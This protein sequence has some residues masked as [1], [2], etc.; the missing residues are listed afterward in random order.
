MFHDKFEI[1]SV[2][3][4]NIS[5]CGHSGVAAAAVSILNI[6]AE[7]IEETRSDETDLATVLLYCE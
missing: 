2:L 7:K 5:C 1:K 3:K 4:V 6:Q